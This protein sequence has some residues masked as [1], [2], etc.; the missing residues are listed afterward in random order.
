[1]RYSHVIDPRTG[2]PAEAACSVTVVAPLAVLADPWATALSVLGPEGLKLLPVDQG[3]EAM[4]VTGP[5]D[6]P[7]VHTTP[8]FRKLLVSGPDF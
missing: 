2:R 1:K 5:P 7:K 8:G 4:I 3:I 6:A